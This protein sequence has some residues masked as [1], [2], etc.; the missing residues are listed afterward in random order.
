MKTLV[1]REG[2]PGASTG[3]AEGTMRREEDRQLSSSSQGKAEAPRV[4]IP[5]AA[6][7]AFTAFDGLIHGVAVVA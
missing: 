3:R 1:S 7:T 5:F 2:I 4:T 6:F